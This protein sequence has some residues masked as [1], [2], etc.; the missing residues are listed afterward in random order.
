VTSQ[1]SGGRTHHDRRNFLVRLIEDLTLL[2]PAS[3]AEGIAHQLDLSINTVRKHIA[4][5]LTQLHSNSQL[6]AVI[7]AQRAGLI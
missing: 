2:G 7:T 1:H 6:E 5:I 3:D 4:A